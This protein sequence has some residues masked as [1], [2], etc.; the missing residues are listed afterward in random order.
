M[1][2]PP[3]PRHVEGPAPQAAA[4]DTGFVFLSDVIDSILP[5]RNRPSLRNHPGV[6]VGVSSEADSYDA[7]IAVMPFGLAGYG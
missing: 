6:E 7:A 1:L 3:V 5:K 4:G 2:C